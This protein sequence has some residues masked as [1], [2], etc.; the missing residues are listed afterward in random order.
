MFFNR[1]Y[2]LHEIDSFNV[3][4]HFIC[5]QAI[6]KYQQRRVRLIRC[7]FT[8]FECREPNEVEPLFN[9]LIFSMFFFRNI[10]CFFFRYSRC[11]L[12]YFYYS[13]SQHQDE[14]PNQFR[15][16]LKFVYFL[17]L[18]KFMYNAFSY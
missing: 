8:N 9:K 5:Y 6:Q 17:Y 18:M 1:R 15:N 13:Y 12:H 10:S 4:S 11:H 2:R 14:L 16:Y 7:R 3:P